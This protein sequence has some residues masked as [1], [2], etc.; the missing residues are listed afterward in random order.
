M[1]LGNFELTRGKKVAS[2][3][4]ILLKTLLLLVIIV[5]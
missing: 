4:N 3:S 5:W 1:K 2:E